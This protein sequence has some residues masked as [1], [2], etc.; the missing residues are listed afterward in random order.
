MS[1]QADPYPTEPEHRGQP[2]SPAAEAPATEHPSHIGRYRVEGLL[3]R[4]G[5]GCVYLAHDEQLQRR[6]AVKVPHRSLVSR[7]E[8]AQPYLNEARIVAGLD[9]PHIVPVFDVGT[10]DDYPFFIVSKYIEGSTLAQRLRGS[11]PA[12]GETVE[13]VATVAETLHYAHRQGLVHRDIKPGNILLDNQGKPYGAD[14]GMALREQDIGKGPRFAGTPAYMSPEQARREGH[15]VDGRSDVFSLG[16]VFYELLTGRRPFHADTREELLEQI[17][18]MEARPPRQWDETVPKEL[19][20]ICL[21]ALS[22]RAADRY[23]TA[24]DLADDLRQ[25]LEQSTDEDKR[26][27]R[28]RVSA[29]GLPSVT[30]AETPV[31]SPQPT[32]ASDS[33][34]I[35]IVPKGL[36]SFDAHDADFFLE[37]L[38]GPRDREGLPDGIRFWKTRIEEMDSDNT[39]S[40]GLLYGPSGCGKS[41]LVKAGLLPRLSDC[42]FAVYVEATA[43]DTEAR[44]LN[45]IRKRCPALAADLGLR[46]TLAAL[47]RGQGAPAGKKVVIV[48]DQFEQWLHA[49]RD[50]ENAELVQALRQCDGGRVQCVVM[51]RDDFWLSV[52]RFLMALEVRLLEGH[53][54]GLVDLFDRDHARKVLIAFA[55][56]F[57]R[58]PERAGERSKEQQEFLSQA[59]AGL[60]QENKV[61]CVRLA[62]FAEMFKGRPWTPASLKAVGGTQGVG[63]TFLEETF[64]AATAPP[65]RRY[66]QKAAR[67]VLKALLPEAGTDIRGHMR[68][69]AELLAASGYAG[70]PKDFDD[71]LRILDSEIRLITPTD[72]EGAP[73]EARGARTPRS[74]ERYYQL[75]HDYLVHSLRDWLTRKQRETRRG[76]AELCLA[77]RAA[78]WSQKPENRHLAAWW[79]W[80]TILLLTRR[81]EWNALQ[82]RM[83]RRAGLVHAVRGALLVL[84]LALLSFAGWWIGAAFEAR[85][86][87]NTLLSASTTDVPLLVRQLGP[88]RRW[89]DPLLRAKAGEAGLDDGKRLHLALALLPVD[90]DQA[91]YLCDRL[92]AAAGPEEVKAIRT[93]LHEHAPASTARFWSVLEAGGETRPRRLRAACALAAF[94]PDDTRWAAV[95]DD[96]ARCLAGESAAFLGE[97]AELLQP[98]RGNLVAPLVRRLVWADAGGFGAFLAVLSVYPDEAVHEL[99]VQLDQTCPPAAKL[100]DKQV[101]AL[102]QALAAVALLRLDPHV[103]R[104][105]GLFHQAQDPTCRTHLIHRCAPLGV[106]AAILVSRLLAGDEKD[107]SARQGLLLALGEYGADQRAEVVRGPLAERLSRLYR[108][109]PDPGVHSAAEWLLHR[110]EMVDRLTRMDQQLP[111]VRWG[112]S[113]APVTAPRWEVNGQ[114]QT[115]AVVPAPGK[116]EIGLPPNERGRFDEPRRPVQIDYPFAVATKLVTVAEFKKLCPGFRHDAKYSPGPDTPVNAVTWYEAAEYC[117]RLTEKEGIPKDQWCYEPNAKGK[118]EE[119]MK[120]KANY[121][122]LLGYRLPREA[123]W[124]Y[125]CRAGTVTPWSFGSD[126]GM[127]GH[128]A[129]YSE[130]A[131]STMHGVGKLKPNGLGLFD[132]HGNALQWCQDVYDDKNPPLSIKGNFRVLRGGSFVFASRLA[133]SA[134]RSGNRPAFRDGYV[135]FRVARTYR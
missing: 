120:V 78:L 112:D 110:W 64:S 10:A 96:V 126:G 115:F 113:T 36:R 18:G 119:G 27:L 24:S 92:L 135:G 20:R 114:G 66:H 89:A 46:D 70:P 26:I 133:R 93:V 12:V 109:D 108:D 38:P 81:R 63:V 124:E 80:A 32:P 3:G 85:A 39:F 50:E 30:P 122:R 5:F 76:R 132:I 74:P 77:E 28:C 61:V 15:R 33:P 73:D 83:M 47:R 128:Y 69:H 99:L 68:S 130:N 42:V 21:K 55:T 58:L 53:N 84:A 79:E 95:G 91:N 1:S 40:V 67:A 59:V 125:V 121:Q 44:L 29:S 14:F 48:L 37:L 88:Y 105:W 34:P 51:V 107:P 60:A 127:V 111:R 131:N 62:L 75:T 45:G 9:H 2:T 41:S 98:V 6:V 35:R 65:E 129:W 118:Y 102:R 49:S 103:G 52:S 106:D 116:F 4:G 72:P 43:E 13:L 23:T 11:R 90:P 54:S 100:E 8:E 134:D 104:A 97:W 87:V 19:E 123:E 56:A 31:P 57:G 101:L 17:T 86:R 117:N 94:A 25:F 7:P 71:L 82:R 22:K 16:V